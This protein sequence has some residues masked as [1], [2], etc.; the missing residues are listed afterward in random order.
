MSVSPQNLAAR[1]VTRSDSGY[2]TAPGDDEDFANR[3]VELYQNRQRCREMAG[4]ARR[5]AESTFDIDQIGSIFEAVLRGEGKEM[6]A[7]SAP[8]PMR[9]S[10]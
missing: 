2:V 4:N 3:A 9:T 8:I 1:I 7:V 5:Y 10:S 6:T